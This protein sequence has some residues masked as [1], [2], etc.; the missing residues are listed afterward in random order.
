MGCKQDRS[1]VARI[2]CA[3]LLAL[4]TTGDASAQPTHRTSFDKRLDQMLVDLESPQ[5]AVR[6]AAAH[7]LSALP[8]WRL[9]LPRT[10]HLL[11][12]AAREFPDVAF[13]Y[14]GDLNAEAVSMDGSSLLIR[15]V[16][17]RGREEHIPV[18]EKY[19]ARYGADARHEALQLLAGL[20]SRD[21]A[22]AT[23]RLIRAGARDDGAETTL[24]WG[25]SDVPDCADIFFPE[26]FELARSNASEQCILDLLST[27]ALYP[28]T[29]FE[30]L[31]RCGPRIVQ[32]YQRHKRRL[33]PAQHGTSR[34]AF[35]SPAYAPHRKLACSLLDL[36][37]DCPTEQGR[38][39]LQ[40]AVRFR[41]PLLKLHA[42]MTLVRLGEGLPQ[43]TIGELAADPETRIE[44]FGKLTM[45]DSLRLFPS[46]YASQAALAESD[47]V[48][49]LINNSSQARPPARIELVKV[50]TIDPQT[51]VGLLDYYVF[52]FCMGE[53][54]PGERPAWKAGVAGPYPRAEQP[55]SAAQATPHSDFESIEA[56][57]PE[58]HI[59]DLRQILEEFRW[60]LDED[61]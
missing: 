16:A 50:V 59:G 47:L 25:W 54:G 29:S 30:V 61:D 40:Q 18:I 56:K 3:G 12:V 58:E 24:L 48:S 45:R 44:L 28:E 52:Q 13:K 46:R 39:E 17:R 38:N 34:A 33:L 26:L 32:L 41:D 36:M 60:Y 6:A 55:T 11:E 22:K 21:A 20:Q 49:W 27:L 57:L 10:I 5:A 7:K 14:D 15:L 1:M 8:D 53:P 43:N 37:A 31:D 35:Y 2:V 19:F 23:M 42:A 51:D 9:T 4:M